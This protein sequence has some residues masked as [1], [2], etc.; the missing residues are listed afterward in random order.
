[1]TNALGNTTKV[2]KDFRGRVVATTD[3]GGGSLQTT[4]GPFDLPIVV[5]APAGGLSSAP[6]PNIST[7]TYDNYG[8]RLTLADSDVRTWTTYNAFGEVA[9]DQTAAQ[10]SATPSEVTSYV[11]DAAARMV[12]RTDREGTTTWSFYSPSALVGQRGK[13]QSITVAGAGPDAN[14]SVQYAYSTAG[15]LATLTQSFGTAS[16]TYS[17]GYTYDTTGRLDVT[18]YPDNLQVADAGSPSLNCANLRAFKTKNVYD[19]AGHLLEIDDA[20]TPSNAPFFKMASLDPDGHLLSETRGAITTTR[21][22]DQVGRLNVM[23]SRAGTSTIYSLDLDYDKNGNVIKRTSNG[24]AEVSTYD[25]LD[26]LKVAAYDA[27][28]NIFI[29][30]GMFYAYLDAAHPH[31][32]THLT[33][34][35]PYPGGTLYKIFVHDADGNQLNPWGGGSIV[36]SVFDKPRSFSSK[37]GASAA[38]T[39]DGA[40][41]R[42]RKDG[43]TSGTTTYTG[44]IYERNVVAGVAHHRF[45]INAYGQTVAQVERRQQGVGAVTETRSYLLNDHLG[46]TGVI[47]GPTGAVI[48]QREYTPFG[49]LKQIVAPPA[50]AAP[51]TKGYSGAELDGDEFASLINL[52]ARMYDPKLGR[53]LSPDPHVTLPLFTQAFNRYSYVW[54]NPLTLNDPSGMDP[55]VDAAESDTCVGTP[56][57]F[58]EDGQTLGAPASAVDAARNSTVGPRSDVV[59]G[60]GAELGANLAEDSLTGLA[61]LVLPGGIVMGPVVAGVI[62]AQVGKP[63]TDKIRSYTPDTEEGMDGAQLGLGIHVGLNIAAGFVGGAAGAETQLAKEA[64]AA[65]KEVAAGGGKA[66]EA[67]GGA[68]A[69]SINA[70]MVLD[71]AGIT[72]A[73]E[74]GSR[75]GRIFARDLPK[76][77]KLTVPEFGDLIGW[78]KTPSATKA[79]NLADAKDIIAALPG[80]IEAL[81]KA[82]VTKTMAEDWAAFYRGQAARVETNPN[83]LARSQVMGAIAEVLP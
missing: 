53:F 60:A 21:T 47:A 64:C 34:G 61:M 2:S 26:R 10:R 8:R 32:V 77:E 68:A 45:Y 28:G 62:A 82:G 3:A 75:E 36:Y 29:K 4:F 39:Y 70:G 67:V 43:S 40:R 65:T 22:Y 57:P 54:N 6:Y 12:T 23:T 38:F 56:G 17:I 42:V 27:A 18:S 41:N 48:E 69:K 25:A 9:T 20:C 31:A 83:A 1:M 24:V 49:E 72:Q 59:K 50:T 78:T 79:Q 16:S 51:V 66:A 55:P 44:G 74:T 30:D 52:N 73:I 80:R 19:Q 11:Y 15:Q 58:V 5:V 46:T 63:I 14:V 81:S 33:T 76:P 35:A 37:S 71:R 13:L 7:F